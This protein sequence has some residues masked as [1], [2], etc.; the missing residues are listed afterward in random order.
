MVSQAIE[1]YRT[2]MYDTLVLF[3]AVFPENE[4]IRKD[5]SFDPRWESTPILPPSSILSQWTLSN[6]KRLLDLIENADMKSPLDLSTVWSKLMTMAS[7]FGRMGIDFRPL[8]ISRLTQLIENKFKRNVQN[9]TLQLTG[10]SR[11]IVMIGIDPASLPQFESSPDSPPVPAA[12]LS[13]W[14]D[15]TVYANHIV[16][17]LNSL[18]FILNPILLST[19]V[20]SLRDSIRSILS[21]LATCHSA[22]PNFT[23]AIRI[24]CT[25]LAPFFEKCVVFFFPPSTITQI[26]GSSVSKQQYLQFIEFDMRQL[27]ASCDGADKIEEYVITLLQ[28]K[29]LAE[30]D[31]ENV[32]N[33]DKTKFFLEDVPEENSE[34]KLSTKEPTMSSALE[35]EPRESEDV[36]KPAEVQLEPF[37]APTVAEEPVVPQKIEAEKPNAETA[38]EIRIDGVPSEDPQQAIVESQT[39][40]IS[41][42]NHESQATQNSEAETEEEWG[43]DGNEEINVDG[44]AEEAKVIAPPEIKKGKND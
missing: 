35:E 5:P 33:V 15:L 42:T 1:I 19:V 24:V 34:Q 31:L 22:S 9:A 7:S 38:D 13:L 4:V 10:S 23:R 44:I 37:T 11:E 8:I 16:D 12:E 17:Y 41:E 20:T 39:P 14:D 21:W 27:A 28:K 30:I 18:R 29:T 43:W 25:C 2:C 40:E 3:L 36:V 32:L 26:F 6:V